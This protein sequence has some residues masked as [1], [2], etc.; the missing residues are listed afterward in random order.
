MPHQR[1][2]SIWQQ[3][4]VHPL[5]VNVSEC[6]QVLTADN[7]CQKL[8]TIVGRSESCSS[9]CYRSAKCHSVMIEHN[10]QCCVIVWCVVRGAWLLSL[11]WY[12]V[13][14]VEGGV[15]VW[16]REGWVAGGWGRRRNSVLSA[17][18]RASSPRTPFLILQIASSDWSVTQIQFQ[19]SSQAGTG[20]RL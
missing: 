7:D 10:L 19:P 13:V 11:W 8:F 14:V 20:M 1:G 17:W 2:A 3:L 4:S 5:L 16:E 15:C 9:L 12:V 6:L 18:A